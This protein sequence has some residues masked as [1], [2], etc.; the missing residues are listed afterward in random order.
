MGLESRVAGADR[1]APGARR[2]GEDG[3]A[4]AGET[5][6]EFV[7]VVHEPRVNA[8]PRGEQGGFEVAHGG[9]L[10]GIS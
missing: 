1:K 7:R 10:Y 2:T 6:S 9:E 8:L 5:A 3:A 4:T